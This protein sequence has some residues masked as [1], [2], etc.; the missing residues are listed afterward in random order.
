MNTSRITLA[1]QTNPSCGDVIAA[2]D[3]A[4]ADQ[5]S[6]VSIRDLRLTQSSNEIDRLGKVVADDESKLNSIFRNPWVFFAVGAGIGIYLGK[7]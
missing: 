7:K 3:K 1:D 6:Q 4:I 2:C 5:K